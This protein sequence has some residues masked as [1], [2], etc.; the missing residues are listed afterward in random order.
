[1]LACAKTGLAVNS[2]FGSVKV[3][4]KHSKYNV[5]P[6]KCLH[7]N[8]L[9]KYKK[10]TILKEP[11]GCTSCAG[12]RKKINKLIVETGGKINTLT[13]VAPI[14]TRSFDGNMELLVFCDCG[15]ERFIRVANFLN[16]RHK[17]CG[18]RGCGDGD[19][20]MVGNLTII[21]DINADKIECVCVCKRVCF[22][23]SDELNSR[24][25]LSCD[26]CLQGMDRTNGS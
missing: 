20:R 25:G 5:Y 1:M 3:V 8:E 13:A 18:K 24:Q 7:C 9:S 16:R 22:R 23:T 15:N 19:N 2:I 11:D 10:P 26:V 4:G 14:Q 21:N 6:I 12:A 17:S